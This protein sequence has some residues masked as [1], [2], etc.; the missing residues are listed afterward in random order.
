MDYSIIPKTIILI[1]VAVVVVWDVFLI[2]TGNHD[3]TFS[4]IIYEASRKWPIIAF[5]F[6]MLCAHLFWQV[7]TR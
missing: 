2:F 1:I 5:V 3:A 6:G 7:Y 4:V